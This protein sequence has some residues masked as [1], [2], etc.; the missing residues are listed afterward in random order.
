MAD[1]ALCGT[2]T[3]WSGGFAWL[4]TPK[5]AAHVKLF[6]STRAGGDPTATFNGGQFAQA[7]VKSYADILSSDLVVS[8]VRRQLQLTESVA[9]LQKKITASSPLGTVVIDV[10]VTDTDAARARESPLRSVT[11]SRCWPTSSRPRRAS[12]SQRS[13]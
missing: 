11:S 10:C 1:H 5:Y 7:R 3:R 9:D 2:G 6:V 12:G 8:A 13:R 4:Q